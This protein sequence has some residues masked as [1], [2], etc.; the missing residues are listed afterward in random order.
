[1]LIRFWE[2]C[3]ANQT[4]RVFENVNLYVASLS[5]DPDSLAQWRAYGGPGSG[6][7]LGLRTHGIVLPSEFRLVPCIYEDRHSAMS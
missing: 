6:F 1:M 4:A 7:S 3:S 2:R 5:E